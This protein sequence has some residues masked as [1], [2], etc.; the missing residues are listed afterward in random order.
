MQIIIHH[1]LQNEILVVEE[2][3]AQVAFRSVNFVW[4]I[5]NRKIFLLASLAFPF[6]VKYGNKGIS[7]TSIFNFFSS[8]RGSEVC[9]R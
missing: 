6:S 7:C 9:E 2:L 3:Y 8:H 4:M 5:Q 1:N